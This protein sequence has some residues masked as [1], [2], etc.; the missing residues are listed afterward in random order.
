MK[1]FSIFL[2][3]V[4]CCGIAAIVHLFGYHRIAVI[5]WL[6]T[7]SYLILMLTITIVRIA[8]QRKKLTNYLASEEGKK[9]VN[10]IIDEHF[11]EETE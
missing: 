4:I 5:C 2:A 10:E 9:A 1:T 7:G 11:N 8:K 6:V 3:T